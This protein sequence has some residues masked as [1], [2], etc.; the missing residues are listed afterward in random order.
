[1]PPDIDQDASTPAESKG[2]RIGLRALLLPLMLFVSC[3]APAQAPG[4]LGPDEPGDT[5]RTDAGAQPDAGATRD[6][7]SLADAGANLDAGAML[8][9]GSLADAGAN[10]DAGAMLDAGSLADAGATPAGGSLPDAGAMPDA[11]SPRTGRGARCRRDAR[12][13]FTRRRRRD[14]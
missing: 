1:M 2:V 5:T 6:G 10:F 12:R 9:A 3:G 7:G 13:W 11:G 8:D 4:D 14:A